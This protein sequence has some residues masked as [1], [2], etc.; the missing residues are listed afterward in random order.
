V[1]RA[2]DR[3]GTLRAWVISPLGHLRL[4]GD[5]GVIQVLK[6]WDFPTHVRRQGAEVVKIHTA[7][8]V[9]TLTVGGHLVYP[10]VGADTTSAMI[11]AN[12]PESE[13]ARAERATLLATEV[14]PREW[15]ILEVNPPGTTR[16]ETLEFPPGWERAALGHLVPGAEILTTF[17]RGLITVTVDGHGVWSGLMTRS[18]ARPNDGSD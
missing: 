3:R 11:R 9:Y 17:G 13:W 8:R 2:T 16:R 14:S 7:K 4:R 15:L 10:V 6:D 5:F 12:G 18:E 1:T